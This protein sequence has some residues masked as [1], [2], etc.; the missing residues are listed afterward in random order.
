MSDVDREFDYGDES[1]SI[2]DQI[3]MHEYTFKMPDK[4]SD[5]KD[6]LNTIWQMMYMEQREIKKQRM[7][8]IK[9]EIEGEDFTSTFH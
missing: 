1:E 5:S 3:D 6:Y 2:D 8:K 9:Q 4:F 7:Y